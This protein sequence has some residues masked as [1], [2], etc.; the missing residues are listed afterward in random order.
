MKKITAKKL[1][2]GLKVLVLVASLTG[3]E[4]LPAIG[5]VEIGAFLDTNHPSAQDV[6]AFEH[7]I[8]HH[9][10]SV[11][12]YTAISPLGV[13]SISPEEMRAIYYHDGYAT[14]TSLQV[15]FEPWVSLSDFSEGKYDYYLSRFVDELSAYPGEVRL[16]FGHEMIEDDVPFNGKEWYPWQD[17]PEEY[18]SAYKHLWTLVKNKGVKNVKFVWSPNQHLS[19]YEILKKYYPGKEYVDWIGIDGYGYPSEDFDAIFE[20]IYK[21]IVEHPEVFGDKDIMLGEFAA[22]E[23]DYKAAW[24]QDA[25]NKIK[26]KYK[27]IKAIYWFN[28]NKEHDWRVDSDENSLKAFRDAVKDPYFVGHSSGSGG[29]NQNP[30][31]TEPEENTKEKTIPI[32]VRIPLIAEFSVSIHKVNPDNTC[33]EASEVDFGVLHFDRKNKIFRSS[34]YY[35]VDIGVACNKGDWSLVHE[36]GSITGPNGAT[37]DSNINVTFVNMTRSGREEVI[38]KLVYGRSRMEFSSHVIRSGWLRI[39]YG[40]ASGVEDAPGARPIGLNKPAGSYVGMV[41]LTLVVN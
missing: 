36:P 27:K 21:A 29:D 31:P 22:M 13:E 15:T 12:V 7:K 9:I 34:V 35:V 33:S 32:R 16:R 39:Y 28:T 18:K 38:K 41:T 14:G 8:G 11:L 5:E 23:G 24:I 6:V 3:W 17:Q 40:I 1:F 4:V 30:S 19:D 26:T 2:A 10:A 20:A 37:L 25:F